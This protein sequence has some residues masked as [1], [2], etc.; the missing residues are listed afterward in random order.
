MRTHCLKHVKQ[1]QEGSRRVASQLEDKCQQVW[2]LL[3][4]PDIWVACKHRCVFTMLGATRYNEQG[5]LKYG[6][7]HVF[8]NNLAGHTLITS[9]EQYGGILW[10]IMYFFNA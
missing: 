6:I 7:S 2:C 3:L 4:A 10:F 1:L 9:D 5:G 8:Q